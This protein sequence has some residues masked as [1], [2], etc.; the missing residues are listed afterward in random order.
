[1]WIMLNDAFF[2]LVSKD[3]AKDEVLVRARIK[4]D[5]EK[6]FNDAKLIETSGLK[7]VVV[8]RYTKSDYL[9]RAVVKRRHML[10]VMAAELNRVVYSNFKA[11]V[12]DNKL[13]DAYNGVWSIMSRLQ[14]LPPY[15]GGRQWSKSTKGTLDDFGFDD[16]FSADPKK[17]AGAADQK[18][19]KAKGSKS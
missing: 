5:L 1:M 3:C 17:A 7:P 4:G 13:H 9:Y 6:V 11:S 16:L 18:A 10:L 19:K 8:T 15:S 14:E 12:R 2:S